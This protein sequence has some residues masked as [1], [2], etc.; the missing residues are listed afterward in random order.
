MSSI[1]VNIWRDLSRAHLLFSDVE[2][3]EEHD[4]SWQE[5]MVVAYRHGIESG[6]RKM[7]RTWDQV[8]EELGYSREHVRKIGKRALKK[9]A[10]D[11]QSEARGRRSYW[12]PSP[13]APIQPRLVNFGYNAH[14]PSQITDLLWQSG[15]IHDR[16]TGH[17][18]LTVVNVSG[19]PIMKRLEGVEYVNKGLSDS[20]FLP[21]Y[22]TIFQLAWS[23][24]M[25]VDAGRKTL[26]NCQMGWN[27]SG[28]IM[29]VTVWMLTGMSGEEVVK[30]IRSKRANALSNRFFGAFLSQLPAIEGGVKD[31]G[32]AKRILEH[33]SSN[34]RQRSYRRIQSELLNRGRAG[35][36]AEWASKFTA[37]A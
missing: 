6:I 13:R 21:H 34:E 26:I 3:Y 11:V 7:P 20:D 29:G 36:L 30:L 25:A 12:S 23:A 28:L 5:E 8:G 31:A 33:L 10:A 17:G 27:R 18:F 37:I 15:Y 14:E 32:M 2:D 19:D 24:R 9:I 22:G 1:G 16:D 35:S 4:L